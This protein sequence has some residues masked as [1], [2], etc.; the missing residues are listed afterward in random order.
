MEVAEINSLLPEEMLRM[1]FSFLPPKD[2]KAAVLVCK[3]W[4]SVGQAP[5]LWSWVTF[6]ADN[7]EDL[8]EQMRLP[9]LQNVS[10]LFITAQNFNQAAPYSCV[11]SL[12]HT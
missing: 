8:V 12:K 9:R 10:R 5:V 6:N 11:K 1:I 2:L 3:L 4:S 7:N